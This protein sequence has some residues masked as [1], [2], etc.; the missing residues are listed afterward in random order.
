MQLAIYLDIYTDTDGTNDYHT[1]TGLILV[2]LS[3]AM[4]GDQLI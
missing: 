1:Y 2:A 4:Q 3:V